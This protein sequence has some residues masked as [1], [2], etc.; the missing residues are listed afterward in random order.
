M[1]HGQFREPF[2]NFRCETNFTKSRTAFYFCNGR[3]N[4]S[5]DKN[6]F[7]H[8]TPL[9]ETGLARSYNVTLRT[10]IKNM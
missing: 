1:Q 7:Y 8:V 2:F 6:K 4:R 3:S 5:G 10:P 9:R